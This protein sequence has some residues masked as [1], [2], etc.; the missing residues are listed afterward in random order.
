[1]SKLNDSQREVLHLTKIEGK[2]IKEA[3][4]ILKISESATKVRVHRA[5][6]A[7]T[8]LIKDEFSKY[9]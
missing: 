4:K 5:S 7:L 2:T 9:A 6:G 8:K 3:A 1:M